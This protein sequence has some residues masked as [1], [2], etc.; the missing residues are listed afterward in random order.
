MLVFA[1]GKVTFI[2]MIYTSR[3]VADGAQKVYQL[4]PTYVKEYWSGFF[5]LEWVR[6]FFSIKFKL[7]KSQSSYAVHLLFSHQIVA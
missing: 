5:L 7:K 1:E 3:T 4:Q 6:R 2:E